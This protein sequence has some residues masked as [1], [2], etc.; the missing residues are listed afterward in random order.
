MV[1]QKRIGEQEQYRKALKEV[2]KERN[3]RDYFSENVVER[4]IADKG[5]LLTYS[6]QIPLHDTFSFIVNNRLIPENMEYYMYQDS[7]PI[8]IPQ[9]VYEKLKP[10]LPHIAE[11]YI[12]TISCGTALLNSL[13]AAFASSDKEIFCDIILQNNLNLYHISN[14]CHHLWTNVVIPQGLTFEEWHDYHNSFV[15]SDLSMVNEDERPFFDAF[16]DLNDIADKWDTQDDAEQ[17]DRYN[18][19]LNILQQSHIAYLLGLYW[20]DPKQL[21]AQ[22]RRAIEEIAHRPSAEGLYDILRQQ[23]D[24]HVSGDKF[25]L[26]SDYF[27]LE[28]ES[29]HTDEFFLLRYDVVKAGPEKFAELINYLSDCCYISNSL[30]V[31]QLLAYRLSGKMRPKSVVSIEWNGRN[32][33]S[34]ELIYLVKMLTERG[35][36]RKM[37]RFFFGPDWPKD[38]YSSYARSADYHLKEMLHRLYPTLPDQL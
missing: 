14:I 35:D 21:T 3:P 2:S 23:Y 8:L 32:G 26:P 15:I 4:A 36:Y 12:R 37:R 13:I 38:R 11:S 9:E 16:N 18:T 1:H 24:A 19:Q 25:V 5:F 34:Y 10:L 20:D 28:N 17:Y 22:E 29:P 33:K 31:K 6:V 27:K 30:P 7:G